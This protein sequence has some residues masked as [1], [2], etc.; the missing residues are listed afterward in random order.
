MAKVL[1][2]EE[3]SAREGRGHRWVVDPP[4]QFPVLS[5]GRRQLG[6]GV[7]LSGKCS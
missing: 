6:S 3:R 2:V 4:P 5:A 1:S 7:G